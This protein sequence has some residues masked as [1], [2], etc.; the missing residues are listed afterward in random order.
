MNFDR[1]LFLYISVYIYIGTYIYKQ[2]KLD[3]VAFIGVL[4][5]AKYETAWC[6]VC[7]VCCHVETMNPVY[8][9]KNKTEH[10]VCNCSTKQVMYHDTGK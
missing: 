5:F 6:C 9:V 8:H 2:E 10:V 1:K 3:D 7:H 4:P